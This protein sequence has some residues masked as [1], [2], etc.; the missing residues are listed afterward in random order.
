[1]SA[2][3]DIRIEWLDAPGISTPELAATWAR[4][5]VWVGGRC[6]TQVETADG[7][8]RRSVYGSLYPLAEWVAAGWWL[9]ASHLRPSAVETRYWSWPNIQAYPWLAQHNLRGADDGM[10]WP[11]LTLVPEGNGTRAVW[12]PDACPGLGGI[13]FVSVGD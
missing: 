9:I 8:I 10:A 2:A 13:R 12:A 4:Y 7:T 11:N 6:V 5:Q 1:M 3:L